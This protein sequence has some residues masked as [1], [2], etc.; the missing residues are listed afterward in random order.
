MAR[1]TGLTSLG[2]A[3]ITRRISAV[4]VC[5]SRASASCFNASARRFSRSPTLEPPPFPDLRA[6]GRLLSPFA[7]AG[8]A[9]RRI[10]ISLPFHRSHSPIHG[11]LSC[12]FSSAASLGQVA[13]T[14]GPVVGPRAGRGGH[15]VGPESGAGPRRWQPGPLAGRGELPPRAASGTP[16]N[17]PSALGGASEWDA[18]SAGS[19]SGSLLAR[20]VALQR[21]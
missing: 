21:R 8:F 4:A 17:M 3:L 12:S 16:R 15:R 11:T 2:E 19:T 9:P 6:S 5:C 18:H 10:G 20:V 14:A 1:N 13:I 7:F